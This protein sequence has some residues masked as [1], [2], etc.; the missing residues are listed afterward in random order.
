MN[1]KGGNFFM[2]ICFFLGEKNKNLLKYLL[3]WVINGGWSLF[4]VV[5]VYIFLLKY[6]VF[7]WKL[8]FGS[9]GIDVVDIGFIVE[10]GYK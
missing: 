1:I 4:S 6:Y 5:L 9:L 2:E 8:I 3:V 7:K 10:W